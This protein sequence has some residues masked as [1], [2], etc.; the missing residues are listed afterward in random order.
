MFRFILLMI[1]CFA[2]LAGC[3]DR[4]AETMVYETKEPVPEETADYDKEYRLTADQV[5]Y[6]KGKSKYHFMP[7]L[8]QD[9]A[10]GYVP[11]GDNTLTVGLDSSRSRFIPGGNG[12]VFYTDITPRDRFDNLESGILRISPDGTAERICITGDCTDDPCLHMQFYGCPGVYWDD[13][14]YFSCRGVYLNEDIMIPGFILRYDLSTREMT[15]IIDIPKYDTGRLDVRNGVLYITHRDDNTG[16][17]F[18]AVDLSTMTACR[19]TT[20]RWDQTIGGVMG[21]TVICCDR[22]GTITAHDTVSG[23][24]Y[25]IS[26][27]S[28][29]NI[30]GVSGDW[31]VWTAMSDAGPGSLCAFH[32]GTRSLVTSGEGVTDASVSPDGRIYYRTVPDLTL[33]RFDPAEKKREK[34]ADHVVYYNT[35]GEKAVYVSSASEEF[36]E[37]PYT[38]RSKTFESGWLWTEATETRRV[39]S[40]LIIGAEGI[41]HSLWRSGDEEVSADIGSVV[42]AGDAVYAAV[43][44]PGEGD[45]KSIPMRLLRIPLY[46]G[47]KKVFDG[48]LDGSVGNSP[49]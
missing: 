12:E 8:I 37:I 32:T 47:A 5:G 11:N 36:R 18:Y 45:Y 19:Y 28:R 48:Y 20:G 30:A 42:C 35:D 10:E 6:V 26:E 13:C 17:H 39:Y 14:L 7:P 24:E 21:S 46:G 15:K 33:Y 34:L 23:T 3:S 44:V 25:T 16:H 22:S 41:S 49:E 9:I 27:G 29:A 40:S 43:Y 38:T 2:A 31:V 4:A 1:L